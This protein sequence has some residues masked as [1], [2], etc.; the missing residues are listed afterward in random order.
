VRTAILVL[1]AFNLSDA[2]A[3]ETYKCRDR[4]GRITYSN[5]ACEKQGLKSAGP[6]RDRTT[7][8]PAQSFPSEKRRAEPARQPPRSAPTVERPRKSDELQ[9]INAAEP[10]PD[11]D[12]EPRPGGAVM[13]P[14]NPLIQRMLR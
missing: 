6:V 13:A 12:A 7:V 11:G 1:L 10:M 2:I 5:S 4:A 8:V 9:A 14:V 3:E